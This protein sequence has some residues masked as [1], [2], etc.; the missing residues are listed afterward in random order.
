MSFVPF[1]VFL[2]L[3][4]QNQSKSGAVQVDDGAEPEAEAWAGVYK[5]QVEKS[6]KSPSYIPQSLTLKVLS[7]FFAIV[8]IA[9][10]FYSIVITRDR[11]ALNAELDSIKAMFVST[12]TELSSTKNTLTSTQSQLSSVQQTLISVQ[13]DLEAVQTKLKYYEE[14]LGV[15][16]FSGEQPT[17]VTGGDL[18][19]SPNLK[20]N[21]IATNPTWQELKAFLLIDPTDDEVYSL[22]F[23]NCV[24]FAEM[25]HNNAEAAGIKTAFVAVHFED[26]EIGHALNA[27]R[28]TDKGLIYVDNTG[29]D[30]WLYKQGYPTEWDK[31]AYLA[32]GK[33]YG[34]ISL[35]EDTPLD[36]DGYESIKLDW[37]SYNT[38]VEAYNKE[39]ARFNKVVSE[40]FWIGDTIYYLGMGSWSVE[41]IEQWEASLKREKRELNRLRAQLQPLWDSLGIV[42]NFEIYW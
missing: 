10:S 2:F 40:G 12:Q 42:T 34:V 23:F 26:R 9:V 5:A 16:V 14:T 11:D 4:M 37:V 6:D 30:E 22:E 3:V 1:G 25:L 41:E 36:Y 15:R 13:N 28:T 39:V 21:S 38:N 27:F 24:S 33:E 8:L 29:T 32:K 31:I 20:N 19:G 18:I 7:I 17:R 35:G